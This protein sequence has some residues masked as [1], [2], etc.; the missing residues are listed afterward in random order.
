[1]SLAE[2]QRLTANEGVLKDDAASTIGLVED[3]HDVLDRLRVDVHDN[4]ARRFLA[5]ADL[6]G[7]EVAVELAREDDRVR[8]GEHLQ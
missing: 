2:H 6:A 5:R 7:D 3:A 8:V 4:V 1:M